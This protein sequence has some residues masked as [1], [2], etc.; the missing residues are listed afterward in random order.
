MAVPAL[1]I[2]PLGKSIMMFIPKGG[3]GKTT[4][5]AHLAVSAAKAGY[6]V[7]AVDFDPQKTLSRWAQERTRH[8]EADKLAQFDV[9]TAEI[10]QWQAVWDHVSSY[11][12]TIFDLPP[13]IEH[14]HAEIYDLS[15]NVSMVLIPSGTSKYD[16]E[17]AVD[18]MNRFKQRGL[19]KVHFIISKVPDT[20]RKSFQRVQTLLSEHGRMLPAV[21]PLREDVNNS[22]DIGLTVSDIRDAQGHTDFAVLWNNVHQELGM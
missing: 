14:N 3:A 10:R 12:L 22:T 5:A 20:R 1:K 13:G 11:D 6:S 18:W 9:A 21:I 17:V 4:I 19:R 7:L 8:P 15:G 16:W 2:A